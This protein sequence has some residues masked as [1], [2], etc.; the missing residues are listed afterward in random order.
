MHNQVRLPQFP[1][2]AK[3]IPHRPIRPPRNRILPAPDDEADR[4]PGGRRSPPRPARKARQTDPF[5]RDQDLGSVLTAEEDDAAID[6]EQLVDEHGEELW[7]EYEAEEET[8]EQDEELV[9]EAEASEEDECDDE[10]ADEYEEEVDEDEEQDDEPY[11][12]ADDEEVDGD[13][14]E[15]EYETEKA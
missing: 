4:E 5:A 7:D 8:I 11:D 1:V 15:D 6:D 13:E 2:P 3:S 14:Y 10:L 9:D 12:E